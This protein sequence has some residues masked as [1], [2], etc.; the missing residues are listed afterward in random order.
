MKKLLLFSCIIA[1]YSNLLSQTLTASDCNPVIGDVFGQI[2]QGEGSPISPGLSGP[3]RTWDYSYL[4]D[5]TVIESDSIQ[6]V[7]AISSGQA[8]P[9]ASIFSN[10]QLWGNLFYKTS[11]TGLEYMGR[12]WGAS[13]NDVFSDTKQ[14]LS[15]P[16]SYGQTFNDQYSFHTYD[17]H[18]CSGNIS[19]TV[20]AQ[21]LLITSAST[22]PNTLRIH[23]EIRETCSGGTT[24]NYTVTLSEYK[25]YTNGIHRELLSIS[26]STTTRPTQ[27]SNFYMIVALTNPDRHVGI[28]TNG[29]YNMNITLF[30]NPASGELHINS[31]TAFH[32]R[33]LFFNVM[34]QAVAERKSS[35]QKET[36]A[37]V[38]DLAP[39]IYFVKVY[40]GSSLLDQ[41][42]VMID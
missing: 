4:N 36:V 2:L 5:N 30:P 25:W 15:Y 19:Y 27:V 40:N 13:G 33:I 35:L 31:E 37:D 16:I 41:K 11:S 20:D 26:N 1:T 14:V 17:S 28:A 39:G 42:K 6:P 22:Y 8:F 24:P 29:S 23:S 10:D 12:G 18:T 21:G 32:D 7:S 38:S 3:S 34:G 9:T